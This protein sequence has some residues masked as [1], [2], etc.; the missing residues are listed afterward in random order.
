MLSS[1]LFSDLPSKDDNINNFSL[2]FED[3]DF[4][5][6]IDEEKNN[7][8]NDMDYYYKDF[9]LSQNANDI[10]HLSPTNSDNDSVQDINYTSNSEMR[11]YG[12]ESSENSSNINTKCSTNYSSIFSIEKVPKEPKKKMIESKK[13][14]IKSML[15]N[16]KSQRDSSSISN[17]DYSYT[18]SSLNGKKYILVNDKVIRL[19][20]ALTQTEKKEIK[21]LRNRISAQ[22]S[23]DKKKEEFKFLI[24]ENKQLKDI[25]SNQQTLIDS[26]HKNI[27]SCNRCKHF[28]INQNKMDSLLKNRKIIKQSNG[29]AHHRGVNSLIGILCVLG[30]L[31]LAFVGFN[32]KLSITNANYDAQMQTAFNPR[33][34]IENSKTNSSDVILSILN[35]H[36][37]IDNYYTNNT[38]TSEAIVQ[39][40]LKN[41]FDLRE[42]FLLDLIAS[43]DNVIIKEKKHKCKKE[44]KSSFFLSDHVIEKSTLPTQFHYSYCFNDKGA[45]NT[46]IE[47][48]NTLPIKV[49]EMNSYIDNFGKNVVSIYVKDYLSPNYVSNI[50]K[51]FSNYKLNQT[52]NKNKN[53]KEDDDSLYLHMILPMSKNNNNSNNE[54]N[55]DILYTKENPTLFELGC[56]V[57]KISK[58]ES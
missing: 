39:K 47:T 23:R 50:E 34:L 41:V 14:K 3:K 25:I 7:G 32:Y 54:N 58:I 55:N 17:D 57:F 48:T 36:F 12:T 43:S 31:A 11:P 5:N 37:P 51:V 13:N 45:I 26:L 9:F 38:I 10:F 24:Q 8:L 30:V 19:T 2:L 4:H 18:S 46:E 16:K 35:E 56:K 20:K 27:S 29:L 33:M 52:K 40:E 22:K 53:K 42:K 1:D 21:V 44:K 15:L 28:I 6:E 49:N